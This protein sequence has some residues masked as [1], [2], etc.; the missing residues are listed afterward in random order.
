MILFLTNTFA[1]FLNLRRISIS[2]VADVATVLYFSKKG[3]DHEL[4][5]NLIVSAL[6]EL[7][8]KQYD[9]RFAFRNYLQFPEFF[10][11]SRA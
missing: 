7:W 1:T 6:R 2:C 3:L 11:L 5:N 10:S 4:F 9:L 8:F